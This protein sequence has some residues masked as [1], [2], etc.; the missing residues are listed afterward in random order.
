MVGKLQPART[1][2]GGVHGRTCEKPA[3]WRV[4]ARNLPELSKPYS[5]SIPQSRFIIPNLSENAKPRTF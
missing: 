1:S 4:G 3:L 2:V 5:L